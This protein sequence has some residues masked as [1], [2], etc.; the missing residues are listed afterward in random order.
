VTLVVRVRG[1]G[2]LCGKCVENG[3]RKQKK[4]KR[5]VNSKRVMKGEGM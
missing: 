5:G 2:I 1:R 3:G 4:K